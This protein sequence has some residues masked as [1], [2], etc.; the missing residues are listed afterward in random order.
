MENTITWP[1]DYTDYLD[2]KDG[3]ME[4]WNNGGMVPFGQ[5][6]AFG[7]ATNHPFTSHQSPF[8]QKENEQIKQNRE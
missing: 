3:R 2:W 4:Y 5:I 6:N 8:Y 7:E 1:T